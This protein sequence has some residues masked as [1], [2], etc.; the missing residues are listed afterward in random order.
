MAGGC[1]LVHQVFMIYLL[2]MCHQAFPRTLGFFP[3]L[4]IYR[5]VFHSPYTLGFGRLPD[6]T[7]LSL[8]SWDPTNLPNRCRN[9]ERGEPGRDGG[10]GMWG[11][12]WEQ[13]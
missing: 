12:T 2:W 11:K 1:V 3:Y 9:K 8:W 7:Y 10:W 4:F 13:E 5:L 6:G